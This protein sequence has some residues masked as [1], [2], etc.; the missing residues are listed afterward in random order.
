M[1]GEFF[2]KLQM[3][4]PLQLTAEEFFKNNTLEQNILQEKLNFL[5]AKYLAFF[6]C[7]NE[8]CLQIRDVV[9]YLKPMNIY[10]CVP[11]V[12]SQDIIVAYNRQVSK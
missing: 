7:N 1:G 11:P 9:E 10:P 2:E 4:A 3:A 6:K 8:M 5:S 12:D